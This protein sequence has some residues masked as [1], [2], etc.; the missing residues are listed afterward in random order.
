M[1]MNIII[2]NII[3]ITTKPNNLRVII[4]FAVINIVLYVC[5]CVYVCVC[6]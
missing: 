3:I 5:E 2:I 1:N 4:T 6:V